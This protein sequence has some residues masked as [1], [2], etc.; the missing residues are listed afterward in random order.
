MRHN[1]ALRPAL[2]RSAM[3]RELKAQVK[4][5][6]KFLLLNPLEVQA[7]YPNVAHFVLAHGRLFE[8]LPFPKLG[9]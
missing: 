7:L 8:P 1:P 2:V 4:A 3:V 5:L 6:N 9:S